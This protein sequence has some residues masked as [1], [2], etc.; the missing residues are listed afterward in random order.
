LKIRAAK[1]KASLALATSADQEENEENEEVEEEDHDGRTHSSE[2]GIKRK[3]GYTEERRLLRDDDDDDD[4]DLTTVVTKRKKV[5]RVITWMC[6][7]QREERRRHQSLVATAGIG[8]A[9]LAAGERGGAVSMSR[10]SA[11]TRTRSDDDARDTVTGGSS[12]RNG[13][14][15]T[16]V[17]YW[18]TD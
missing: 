9:S 16:P 3:K 12:S 8:I 10:R 14:D 1:W 2:R 18:T 17:V 13:T 4:E 15:Y 5:P 11:R 7:K 6:S